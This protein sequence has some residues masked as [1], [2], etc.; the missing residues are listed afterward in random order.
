MIRSES[1]PT[2]RS[3]RVAE[4]RSRNLRRLLIRAAR[5]LNAIVEEELHARGYDDIRL[6]HNRLLIHLDFEGNSITEVAERAR[7][8]KQA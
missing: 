1:N 8:T 2:N 7:L 6:A 4:A 5:S 3:R